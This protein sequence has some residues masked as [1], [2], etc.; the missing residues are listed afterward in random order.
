LCEA[1]GVLPKV[2][3]A[4]KEAIVREWYR[5]GHLS[6]TGVSRVVKLDEGKTR[7]VYDFFVKEV[8]LSGVENALC[9]S[10]TANAAQLSSSLT[11]ASSSQ[12]RNSNNNSQTQSQML[13]DD[14]SPV[15]EGTSKKE[16][17]NGSSQGSAKKRSR[18]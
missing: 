2:F 6:E 5:N 9:L 16:V 8:D 12:L 4:M 14:A 13:G 10:S 15:V 17:A 3:L 11:S 1:I 7:K 18:I